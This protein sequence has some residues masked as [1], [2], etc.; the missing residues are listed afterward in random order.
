MDPIYHF[1]RFLSPEQ[2][3]QLVQL[4]VAK[5]DSFRGAAGRGSLGPRYEVMAGDDVRAELPELMTLWEQ[6][7]QPLAA[8]LAGEAIELFASPRRAVRV[9]RY[10]QRD[11]GFRWHFDGHRYAALLTLQNTNAGVTEYVAPG[12]SRVL[13]FALYPLYPFPQVF[14]FA[15]HRGIAAAAGDLVLMRGRDLLHRGVTLEDDGE[16]LLVVFAYDGVGRR[17]NPV[18]D[19]IARWLNFSQGGAN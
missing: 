4:T 19:R 9:Q 15:P 6:R 10:A 12:L 7:I 2:V 1:P 5:Q 14:S 3:E 11:H 17:P 18:R 16:R 13:R 8:D